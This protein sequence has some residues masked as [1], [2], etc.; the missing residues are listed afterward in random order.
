MK[1]IMLPTNNRMIR[2][3][4]ALAAGL[5]VVQLLLLREPEYALRL[6]DATSD[7][8]I[9]FV[10]FGAIAFFIWLATGGRWLLMVWAAA[11]LVGTLDE[12]Q[13]IQTPGRTASIAD[14]AADGAGATAA[15]LVLTAMNQ[16]KKED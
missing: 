1:A 13:Q 5:I 2:A 14:L 3:L 15:L 9:H 7:K 6:V 4:S 10:V 8:L 16:R 12:T 11:V